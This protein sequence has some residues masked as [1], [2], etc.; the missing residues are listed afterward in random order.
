MATRPGAEPSRGHHGLMGRTLMSVPT[1]GGRHQICVR[2][3]T[4]SVKHRMA[5]KKD[6]NYAVNLPVCGERRGI[7]L[8]LCGEPYMS[9]MTGNSEEEVGRMWCGSVR[10]LPAQGRISAGSCQ[11]SEVI[12]NIGC[13]IKLHSTLNTGLDCR[14]ISIASVGH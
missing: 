9:Q 6:V 12:S 13:C 1:G 4:I 11:E 2:N 3:P 5:N 10:A 14:L 8:W 7:F